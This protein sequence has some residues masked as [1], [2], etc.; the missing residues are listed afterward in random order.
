MRGDRGDIVLGW[1]TRL[2][3]GLALMGLVLFDVVALSLVRFQGS[4]AADDAAR[5]AAASWKATPDIQKAYD[6]ALLAVEPGDT[7]PVESFRPSPDGSFELQLRRTAAT[8]LVE[9]IP[10]LRE[11]A[12]ATVSGTGRPPV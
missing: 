2:T 3:V 7:L 5:A 1:L 4:E 9:K 6:A 11:L 8:L 12:T 10:P